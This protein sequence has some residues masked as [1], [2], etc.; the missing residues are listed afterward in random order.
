MGGWL[1]R[2]YLRYLQSEINLTLDELEV[3][4]AYPNASPNAI[5]FGVGQP[6]SHRVMRFF[7]DID[8]L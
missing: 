5:H 4:S 3:R 2:L 7:A 1:S 6:G 8:L